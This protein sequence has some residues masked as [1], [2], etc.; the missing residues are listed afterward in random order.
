M[1]KHAYLITQLEGDLRQAFENFAGDSVCGP[2]DRLI[3]SLAGVILDGHMDL[4]TAARI[5]LLLKRTHGG[6]GPEEC[7]TCRCPCPDQEHEA[8]P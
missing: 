7:G 4:S 3:E 5:D 1:A 6:V 8:C 2:W